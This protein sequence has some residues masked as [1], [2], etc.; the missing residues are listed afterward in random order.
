MIAELVNGQ[1]LGPF[2]NTL[3]AN[4]STTDLWGSVLKTTLYRGDHRDRV[5]LQGHDRLGRR[6]GRG[7]RGQPGG[8]D[9]FLAIFAFDYVFTQTLLATHPQI[10]VSIMN[11]CFA[12]P[13][14]WLAATGEIAGS[15]ATSSATS[16]ACACSASSARR[17]ASRAS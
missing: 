13:R 7:S 9:H 4:A 12:M 5:L 15:P 8:G 11:E 14:E 10:L 1:P 16:G 6:R 17:C 2:W 3:F